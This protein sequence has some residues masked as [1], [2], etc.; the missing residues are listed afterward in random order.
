[1]EENKKRITNSENLIITKSNYSFLKLKLI[2]IFINDYLNQ[3]PSE[4][5]YDEQNRRII[6]YT[7]SCLKKLLKVKSGDIYYLLNKVINNM[8]SI[9]ML[10]AEESNSWKTVGLI[11]FAKCENNVYEIHFEKDIE[12]YLKSISNFSTMNRALTMGFTSIYAFNLYELLSRELYKINDEINIVERFYSI[13]ELHFYLGCVNIEKKEIL[14]EIQKENTDLLQLYKTL[15]EEDIL[16][17]IFYNFN[18]NVISVGVN[19]I[20]EKSDLE[21]SYKIHKNLSST[22]VSGIYFYVKYKENSTEKVEKEEKIVKIQTSSIEEKAWENIKSCSDF[23]M[24][25]QDIDIPVDLLELTK[26]KLECAKLYVDWK[27]KR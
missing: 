10:K 6:N 22:R 11:S 8:Q 18:K 25:I 20:N 15:D 7:S 1:M 9:N 19:Q 4:Y 3:E 23:E 13:E 27:L 14:E 26:T 24:F 2:T 16:H 21:I 12:K 17:Y 5:K